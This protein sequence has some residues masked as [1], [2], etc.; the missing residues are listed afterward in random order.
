MLFLVCTIPFW[1][2]NVIRMISWI[3]LLGRNGLVNATLMQLGH[4]PRSRSSSC[5]SPIFAVVLAFVHLYTLFMVVPIFNSMMRIDRCLLEAARD[6]GATGWQTLW[7]VIC[8][9]R[10]PG[11]AIGSIFVVTIVMGDFVTVRHDGRPADRLGR[12]MIQ[13]RCRCCS[14]PPAAANAVVLLIVVLLIVAAH[15]A[16]GRHPQGAVSDARQARPS[17]FYWL[18]AFFA[19]F[20]LFLYGPMITILDPVVPGTEGGLTFPMSGVSLHWFA[21][22]FEEPRRRRHRGCASPL[23]GAR[24]GG[25]GAHRGAVAAGRARLPHA[26]PRLDRRCSISRSPA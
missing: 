14:I 6:A 12:Q 20:V 24:R 13:R 2:S 25:D 19:L 1:T 26:L 21:K 17:A 4:D 23:A 16:G 15:D 11:I 22:L 3:P 5:C 9:C 7:N 10:K 18:A 8:R